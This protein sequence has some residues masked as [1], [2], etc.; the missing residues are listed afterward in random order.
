MKLKDYFLTQEEFELKE[1]SFGIL[2]TTPQPKVENLSNYYQSEKYISHTDSKKSIFDFVYQYA[3]NINLKHKKVLLKKHK[4]S[5]NLLDYGCGTGDF[6]NYIKKDFEAEGIEPN[7]HAASIAVKKSNLNIACSTDLTLFKNENFDIITL[8]HV[9]EHIPNLKEVSIQLKRILKRDGVLIIAVPNHKSYDAQYYQNFWAAY[10]VP[11]HLWH[12]SKDSMKNWWNQFEM[13]IIEVAPMKLDAFYVSIL[14]E[15]Y[16]KKNSL[17]FI[18][19][20]LRGLLSNQKAKKSGEH[21][22]LIYIF[23]KIS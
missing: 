7:K 2:E 12:F 8:W 9:L 15:Q 5:G 20:L 21:S 18:K 1:N 23:K 19:G 13:K 4:S 16:R 11:R 3:K 10:D 14:S 17:Y 6:L 22:S